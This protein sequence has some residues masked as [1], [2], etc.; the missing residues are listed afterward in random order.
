MV[1]AT[2]LQIK[3]KPEFFDDDGRITAW[4]EEFGI[5]APGD[6][7]EEA[8]AVLAATVRYHCEQLERRGTLAAALAKAGLA[9]K[10]INVERDEAEDVV[11]V[12][13]STS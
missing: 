7:R 4:C 9:P 6:T 12:L 8:S 10:A 2:F 3:Y 5:A 13:N 1:S 11:L